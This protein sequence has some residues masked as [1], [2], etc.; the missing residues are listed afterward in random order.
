MLA[1]NVGSK[2][3]SLDSERI[4]AKKEILAKTRLKLIYSQYEFKGD[5]N[6]SQNFKCRITELSTCG[7]L[8]C[9]NRSIEILTPGRKRARL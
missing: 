7:N 2:K 1:A 3:L 5:T 4:A 8:L 6:P 9:T